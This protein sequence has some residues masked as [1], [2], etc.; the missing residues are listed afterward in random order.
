MKPRARISERYMRKQEAVGGWTASYETWQIADC[1]RSSCHHL[2]DQIILIQYENKCSL[3]A[4]Y[5]AIHMLHY[6]TWL[7]KWTMELSSSRCTVFL[8][9]NNNNFQQLLRNIKCH[10]TVY[11]CNYYYYR[12]LPAYGRNKLKLHSR[13]YKEQ[14]KFGVRLL[15]PSCSEYFGAPFPI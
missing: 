4:N 14:I 3:T 13:M 7:R 15:P 1:F 10:S 2:L 5:P 11:Y 8:M 6:E 9:Q 12:C